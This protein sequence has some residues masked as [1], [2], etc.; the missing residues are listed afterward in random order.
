M[1]DESVETRM[2]I[3]I[4]LI[5][6]RFLDFAE[7]GLDDVLFG[8]DLGMD[9]ITTHLAPAFEMNLRGGKVVV[10]II[11]D[12]IHELVGVVIER[13][14]EILSHFGVDLGV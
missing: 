6:G 10:H 9:V 2:N 11:D 3:F 14:M 12:V 7:N 4:A 13:R 5:S 8:L 1:P